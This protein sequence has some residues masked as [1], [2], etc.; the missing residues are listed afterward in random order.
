MTWIILTIIAYFF[1]AIVAIID[2]FLISKK[3]PQPI[4]Y[5]FYIGILSIL[6][7][8]L[9]FLGGLV[10]PTLGQFFLSLL[11]GALFILSLIFFFK[12]LKINEAS[13]TVPLIGSFLPVFSVILSFII[14]K[15]RLTNTA[16]VSCLILILAGFLMSIRI[17]KNNHFIKG[18]V[19]ILFSAFLFALSFILSKIIYLQ[20]PFISGFI[21]IRLG[22]F[23]FSLSFLLVPKI[24]KIIFTSLKETD[25]KISLLFLGN[26]TLA[27]FYFILLN[28]AIYLNSVSLI[29]ALQGMQYVFIFFI[30]I[31]IS[32]NFPHFFK[33]E[34]KKEIIFQK[35]MAM[36][37][38][39]I[40]LF[41]LASSK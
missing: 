23:I 19:F 15:E 16:L 40:G 26:Q 41:I 6:A 4:S 9:I 5:A 22:S 18:W 14:L 1:S 8:L 13:R 34:L 2:K 33:E 3:I 36:V 7:L 28:V 10:W 30:A 25:Q 27:A 31:I 38:I 32:K 37:L 11:T 21:W 17:K 20:L 24:R 39:L 29:N 12:A 35:I